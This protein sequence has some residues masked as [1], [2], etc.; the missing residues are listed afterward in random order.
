[1]FTTASARFYSDHGIP[2]RPEIELIFAY[3]GIWRKELAPEVARETAEKRLRG[4]F[5]GDDVNFR[6]WGADELIDAIEWANKS[7]DGVLRGA[8]LIPLPGGPAK[9]YLRLRTGPVDRGT[10]AP[11]RWQAGRAHFHRQRSVLPRRY[12]RKHCQSQSRALGLIESLEKGES[13]Q[14]LIRHN[15][16]TITSR[17]AEVLP[18]GT[19]QLHQFQIVNGAQTAF[20][21]HRHQHLIEAAVVSVKIV[22]TED[23]EI[24]NGVI[25]G[26]N[27]QSLVNAYDMLARRR[28][29]GAMQQ[30]SMPSPGIARIGFGFS[31]AVVN[32]YLGK[33]YASQRFVTLRNLMEAFASA[34]L[35]V[36]HRVHSDSGSLLADVP[37]KIFSMAHS[38]SVYRAMAWLSVTAGSGPSGTNSLGWT[39]PMPG[40]RGLTL[41][42]IKSAFALRAQSLILGPRTPDRGRSTR[43][44]T[45]RFEGLRGCGLPRADGASSWDAARSGGRGG[46]RPGIAEFSAGQDQG[47]H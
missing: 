5:S 45:D 46:S 9:G 28:E 30:G 19:L 23:D 3:A 26:A 36:P 15:G 29:V 13:D 35:A 4:E 10:H 33:A 20:V 27:T 47:L 17:R 7:V 11:A 21:L 18:D 25:L 41:H 42:A 39:K 24:K 37:D 31:A 43:N 40:G 12:R 34:C 14:I 1:L 32:G 8:T 22:V 16:I 44:V 6:M 38:P 2:F